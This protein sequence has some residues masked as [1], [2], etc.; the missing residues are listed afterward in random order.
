LHT[1]RY[2]V[3]AGQD[4]YVSNRLIDLLMGPLRQPARALF[5]LRRIVDRYPK[6][7]AATHAR[8]AIATIKRQ[9]DEATPR[10]LD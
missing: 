8:T 6:S 3:P 9:L 4:I 1:I 7:S 2:A 5:E 10:A